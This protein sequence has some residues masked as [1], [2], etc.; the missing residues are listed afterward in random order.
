MRHMIIQPDGL[1]TIDSTDEWGLPF[2]Q[3]AVGGYIEG[4]PAPLGHAGYIN[5]EGKIEGLAANHYATLL[6][7]TAGLR[8]IIAGN[9]VV[10]GPVDRQG[11]NTPLTLEFLEL[12]VPMLQEVGAQIAFVLRGGDD[13]LH[14]WMVEMAGE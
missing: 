14:A 2:L 11:N 1:V 9:M 4:T 3:R 12:V 6:C 10:V 13:E 8:D 5:E 7:Y